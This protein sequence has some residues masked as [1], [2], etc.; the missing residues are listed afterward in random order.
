MADNY[1]EAI[2]KAVGD[3]PYGA[4]L[5]AEAEKADPDQKYGQ[6]VVDRLHEVI[7]LLLAYERI[8]K[9]AGEDAKAT[10]EADKIAIAKK[11]LAAVEAAK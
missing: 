6:G 2:K 10:A 11:A 1:V 8:H 3:T 7:G 5:V 4:H 9:D